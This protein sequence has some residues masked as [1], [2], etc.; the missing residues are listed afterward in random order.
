MLEPL[1]NLNLEINDEVID[2]A[3]T[4]DTK[5]QDL[6]KRCPEKNARYHLFNFPHTHE[7]DYI[8]SLGWL[9]YLTP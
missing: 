4:A 3:S 6:P 5:V 8:E 2:L 9:I 7:G 1:Y